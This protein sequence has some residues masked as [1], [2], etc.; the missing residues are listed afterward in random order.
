M[1]TVRPSCLEV[2]GSRSD[3]LKNSRWAS[4]KKISEIGSCAGNGNSANAQENKHKDQLN[5]PLIS[6]WYSLAE[7]H[8]DWAYVVAFDLPGDETPLAVGSSFSP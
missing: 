4:S 8:E 3:D 6:C 7:I 5:E 1:Q 2:R